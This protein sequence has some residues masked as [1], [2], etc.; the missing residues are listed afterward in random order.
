MTPLIALTCSSHTGPTGE[1]W[2]SS[3]TNRS[4]TEWVERAGGAPILLPNPGPEL[5]PRLLDAVDGLLLTGGEDIHPLHYGAQPAKHLGTVDVP[6]DAFELPL[7]RLALARGLPVFGI[8]RGIQ[9]LNVAAG[10]T[11][12]QDL[13]GDAA[14]TVQH[15]MSAVGGRCVHHGVRVPSGSRLAAILGVEE[16]AVNSYHHQ[17]VDRVGAGLA[18]TA[19][20][21]DG[22]IEGLE[23][24]G[25]AFVIAVQ[26]HPEVMAADHEPSARLFAA[27]MAACLR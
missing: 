20:A 5:A 3:A 17:A 2:Q 7:A 21:C 13:G 22:T 4:Y 11:L 27:F 9:T 19:T 8:C 12:R 25:E 18:V 24:T 15:R 14:A 26:W 10:G 6:R 1:Y 16:L 23:G